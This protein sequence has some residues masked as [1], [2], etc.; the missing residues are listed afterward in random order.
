[1]AQNILQK[2]PQF[3]KTEMGYSL[4]AKS[5]TWPQPSRACC[6]G[7][8]RK[9]W[10]QRDQQSA[11]EGGYSKGLLKQLKGGNKAFGDGFGIAGIYL[12][13]FIFSIMLVCPLIFENGGLCGKMAVIL[14][15][16]TQYVC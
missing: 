6:F 12:F 10:K 2:Q 5:L 7:Y 9:N 14:K 15:K 8:W 3:L 13:L 4:M 11:S 16:L 1:M